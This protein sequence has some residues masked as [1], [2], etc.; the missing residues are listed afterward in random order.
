MHLWSLRLGRIL[1]SCAS[2]SGR[3]EDET[4]GDRWGHVSQGPPPRTRSPPPPR[5]DAPSLEPKERPKL[6]LAPR[7]ATKD[8]DDGTCEAHPE[9]PP[10]QPKKKVTLLFP[11]ES[12][13]TNQWSCPYSLQRMLPHSTLLMHGCVKQICMI[14]CGLIVVHLL[15]LTRLRRPC[16][17]ILLGMQSP[18]ML[19]R[20]CARLRRGTG[21]SRCASLQGT[22]Q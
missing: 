11:P 4:G 9:E 22:P 7:G 5:R 14:S 1:A 6:T 15:L 18:S 21:G 8:A 3:H 12:L 10:P 20:K 19:R 16:R 2:C 13:A 17:Q